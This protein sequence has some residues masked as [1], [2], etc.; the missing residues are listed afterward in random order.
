MYSEHWI[1]K[2]LRWLLVQHIRQFGNF[3]RN[4]FSNNRNSDFCFMELKTKL[5][6]YSCS[7]AIRDNECDFND[8]LLTFQEYALTW[9]SVDEWSSV[10][11]F[12]IGKLLFFRYTIHKWK[13]HKL[14]RCKCLRPPKKNDFMLKSISLDSYKK[15]TVDIIYIEGENKLWSTSKWLGNLF[16]R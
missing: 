16:Y 6:Y 10:H 9:V 15:R 1:F 4:N 5:K 3:S 2:Y 8:L 12:L 11:V 14:V 13:G 7:F